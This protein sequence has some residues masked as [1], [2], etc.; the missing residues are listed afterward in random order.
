MFKKQEMVIKE[1]AA[2]GT[3]EYSDIHSI[4][5]YLIKAKSAK[6]KTIG[7]YDP[8]DIAQEV[9]VKCFKIMHKYASNKGSAVNFFGVCI[10]NALIDLIRRHTLRKS[11]VCFYCLFN[12]RGVCQYYENVDEC[13][14]YSR[15]LTNKSSK[16]V[17]YLLRGN[18]EFEWGEIVGKKYTEVNSYNLESKILEIREFLTEESKVVFDSFM[19]NQEIGNEQEK[20]LF[21]EVKFV[22][23]KY[24]D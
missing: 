16:E 7:I 12:I 1:K 23:N 10:D 8:D 15:F 13:K 5:E 14:K 21:Q 17:I 20:L 6:I 9:R 24:I 3:L 18:S 2:L 22:I 11:N 4:V 19:G